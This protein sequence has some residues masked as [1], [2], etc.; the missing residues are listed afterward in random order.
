MRFAFAA[1]G[2]EMNSS[3]RRG[4]RENVNGSPR[5]TLVQQLVAAT[6]AKLPEAET[7]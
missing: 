3:H 5:V 2:D 6:A 4:E 7:L 1:N